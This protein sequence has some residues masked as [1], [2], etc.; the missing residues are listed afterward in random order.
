M[1]SSKPRKPDVITY[2]DHELITP[3]SNKLRKTLRYIP[4]QN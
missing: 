1:A 3:D 4:E 2:G